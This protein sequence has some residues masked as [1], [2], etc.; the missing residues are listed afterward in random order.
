MSLT[1]SGLAITLQGG[2][3]GIGGD[4][5]HNGSVTIAPAAGG[6]G[7]NAQA[8]LGSLFMSAGDRLFVE[9]G[10]GNIGGLG[11]NTG[12]LDAVPGANGNASVSIGSLN[13]SGTV[14]MW[15]NNLSLQVQ[16]GY[17]SGVIAGNEVI[18][19]GGGA[20]TLAGANT[21][22]GGT[23]LEN[24]I[25][26][27]GN[28]NALGTGNVMVLGGTLAVVSP[29][30]VTVGGNYT[31]A[32]GATL[33]LN[34]TGAVPGGWDGLRVAGTAD[35][36]GNLQL[37][38]GNGAIFQAHGLETFY[39]LSAGTTVSG[40]FAGLV[41]GI[42]ANS[43]SLVYQS[44]NEVLLELTGPSFQ[45][46]GSTSN[47]QALGGALDELN[48]KGGN[49]N[50][51]GALDTAVNASLPGIYNQISPANLTPLYQMGF[52]T[53][54]AEAGMVNQRLFQLF[55]NPGSESN[56]LSWNGEGPR[57]AANVPASQ[58]AGMARDL[59]PQHWSAFVNGM[60]NFGTIT[61]DS[62][63]PGYQYSI[64]GMTAGLDYRFS[65]NL[66]GGLLFGYS[67]S[68]T[69]QSTGTVNA[70]GGQVGLYG[71]LKEGQLHLEAL[72]EGGVNNYTTQRD[73]LGGTATGSTRG[74]MVSVQLG[75]G[76]DWKVDQLKVGPFASGQYT[77]VNINAFNESGSMAPLSFGAQGE[78]YL[79]SDL[80]AAA[81]RNWD[82]GGIRLSPSLS[83]AWE[84]VY[85]GNLDSLDASL[86]GGGNFTVSGPQTGTNAAVIGA[87]LNAGFAKGLN[88]FVQYQGKVGLADYAEQNLSGGINVG[89]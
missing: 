40:T 67:Q 31:Q 87:G 63:A 86:G 84:H 72:A 39:I 28:N 6:Q 12:Y 8:T 7:G 10:S 24:G 1:A 51:L 43:V 5:T 78:G 55:G 3:G 57:F 17:F 2:Q 68:G 80:G 81:S 21:Y 77:N 56:D 45:S 64:G 60:G 82:L 70:T 50:L 36:G 37:V 61:G 62:N 83:V 65:K 85:Q 23:T 41:D 69:S 27:L 32:A 19:V 25:L 89:F 33:Q 34:L 54:Q 46:L 29:L 58:E 16:S 47:Q 49:P 13:G 14:T 35:L 11:N 75:A 30:A 74:Q 15:G 66:A 71:G 53:A 79:T 9:A 44:N 52:A 88:A 26:G 73:A 38:S 76:Y 22:S 20:L 4:G 42:S 59:Q 18:E 48:K